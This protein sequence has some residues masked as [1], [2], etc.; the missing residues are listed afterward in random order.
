M[1]R[2]EDM[3]SYFN[4]IFLTGAELLC[5]K[6]ASCLWEYFVGPALLWPLLEVGSRP[7]L[8]SSYGISGSGVFRAVSSLCIIE[9][10]FHIL[11][12][13]MLCEAIACCLLAGDNCFTHV[14]ERATSRKCNLRPTAPFHSLAMPETPSDTPAP[15]PS[16]STSDLQAQQHLAVQRS[17]EA[18]SVKGLFVRYRESFLRCLSGDS[19]QIGTA[20]VRVLVS[21]VLHP[22]LD[23]DVLDIC[24][25]LPV[26]TRIRR[27]LLHELTGPEEGEGS[28]PQTSI[29][30]RSS[31]RT[32]VRS[33]DE[34]FDRLPDQ[35]TH[36][37]RKSANPL[38]F[39]R[40]LNPRNNKKETRSVTEEIEEKPV[41]ETPPKE[42][43]K[44]PK[45]EELIK[46]LVEL[47]MLPTLPPM[48][49]SYVTWI[50]S[51]LTMTNAVCSSSPS[52]NDVSLNGNGIGESCLES[53]NTALVVCQSSVADEL[54]GVWCDALVYLIQQQWTKLR[55]H[56]IEPQM[57]CSSTSLLD[58]VFSQ[59]ASELGSALY[60]AQG[61]VTSQQLA[62]R[63]RLGF[64]A[65]CALHVFFKIRRLIALTQLKQHLLDGRILD[66]SGL[67]YVSVSEMKNAE[68]KEGFTIGLASTTVLPC[69]VAF[70]QGQEKSAYYCVQ[71][72]PDRAMSNETADLDDSMN[73]IADVARSV[74][75]VVLASPSI[76]RIN[77]G[78]VISAA[79][80]LG[81]EPRVD[82]QHEAWLHLRVRPSTLRFL[83][84]SEKAGNWNQ[85]PW[86]S[87]RS[88]CDGHWVLAFRNPGEA[89]HAKYM[90][91][92]Y[93]A[94][95]SALYCNVLSP[96]LANDPFI[97]QITPTY[98]DSAKSRSDYVPST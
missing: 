39:I 84:A 66:A 79:P 26:R 71:G 72:L 81:S 22:N 30:P 91:Q 32:S 68:L 7:C 96:L 3:L 94:K 98:Q 73:E 97:G 83:D 95:L 60:S 56:A 87:F 9:R 25:V 21:L 20:A 80:L 24:G 64:S 78:T 38:R 29:P 27:N 62:V 93:I 23:P 16:A 46:A 19:T 67:A 1:N 31:S 90:T 57:I 36:T 35:P 52:N 85:P 42:S 89:L 51:Q 41:E 14:C 11:E 77:M 2:I 92:E 10:L 15:A 63:L 12:S 37:R 86:T 28:S 45:N 40:N 53:V 75:Y 13:S 59:K 76:N 34:E 88:L 61:S 8:S 82:P 69:N 70:S 65:Q 18:S 17:R 58:S 5:S 47:T 74:P 48:T 33:L 49:I 50:I 55:H 54:R 4:D 43:S 6:L 44:L